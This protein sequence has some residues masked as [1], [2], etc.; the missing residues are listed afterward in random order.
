TSWHASIAA[1]V[2]GFAPTH[3]PPKQVSVW[4]HLLASSQ[5]VP[6]SSEHVPFWA[7]PAAIEHA[8]QAPALHAVSQHTPS[9][10]K[11]LL[12]SAACMQP[13]PFCPG[14]MKLPVTT[15]AKG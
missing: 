12:Q 9:T 4:V 6:E 10:Q 15:S 8:S 14:G 1:Q 2:T 3:M 13:A 7:A 11:P 5:G